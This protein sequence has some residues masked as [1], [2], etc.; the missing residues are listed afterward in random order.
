MPD[1][2]TFITDAKGVVH[3]LL[4]HRFDATSHDT[5]LTYASPLLTHSVDEAFGKFKE[6]VG[7]KLGL[8]IKEFSMESIGE[9]IKEQ[10]FETGT[11][12]TTEAVLGAATKYLG[13]Q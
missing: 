3:D 6:S 13:N 10:L 4:K 12:L 8:D 1:F 5:A 2:G 11:R 7:K 9:Q